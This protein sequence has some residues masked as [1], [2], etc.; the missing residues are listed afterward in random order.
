MIGKRAFDVTA[1]CIALAAFSPVLAAAAVAIR[2]EDGGPVLFRQERVGR[3]G[4][5]FVI[6]KLRTM[7]DGAVT[8]PGAWL[9]ATG[10][11]ELPQFWD[12]LR[13]EMSVVGPRPL[14]RAD[15]ERLG[16][17]RHPARA[18]VRPGITGPAQVL[19]PPTP[20]RVLAADLAYVREA[21]LLGDAR[22]V[23]WS[24]AMN[25]VGKQRVRAHL[26][27]AAER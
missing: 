7:R 19:A 23:A 20:E 12:V 18:T 9:R 13:G 22:L 2:L 5:T 27:R 1:A 25:V 6:H 14:T 8:R 4:R 26:R 3:S 17:H 15:H 24:F 11:D 16:F 21:G 10:L